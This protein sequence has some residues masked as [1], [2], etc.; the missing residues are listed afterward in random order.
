[1]SDNQLQESDYKWFLGN[2]RQLFDHYGVVYLAIKEQKVLG[3]Y[4]SYA[5]A[6]H[7]TEKTEPIGSFIVQYCNGIETGYT[8]Y[9]S[10]T[11]VMGA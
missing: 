2:Y 9:I 3:A 5:E 11:F 1:M 10:S 4:P 6:V 8:N 7:E